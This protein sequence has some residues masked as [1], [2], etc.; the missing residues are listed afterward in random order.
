MAAAWATA[1]VVAEGWRTCQRRR[2]KHGVVA[3]WEDDT[4]GVC[5]EKPGLCGPLDCP[6]LARHSPS[7]HASD[8][9]SF[10]SRATLDSAA[11]DQQRHLRPRLVPLQQRRCAVF[12]WPPR[13]ETDPGAPAQKSTSPTYGPPGRA[14]LLCSTLLTLLYYTLLYAAGLGHG[15][16]GPGGHRQLVAATLPPPE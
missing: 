10:A 1:V 11:V 16:F 3:R 6:P 5:G 9:L 4:C 14:A 2:Q 8:R 13:L 7:R 12:C 15:N